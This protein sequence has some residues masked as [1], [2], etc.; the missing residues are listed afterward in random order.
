MSTFLHFYIL[1][2]AHLHSWVQRALYYSD[3]IANLQLG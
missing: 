3:R 1:S 2:E